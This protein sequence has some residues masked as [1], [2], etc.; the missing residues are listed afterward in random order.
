MDDALLQ[1]DGGVKNLSN[2]EVKLACEQRGIDVL[3]RKHDYLRDVLER[4]LKGR[5]EGMVLGM[6]LSRP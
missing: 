6:L 3:G 1:R 5:R 4:W 2:D